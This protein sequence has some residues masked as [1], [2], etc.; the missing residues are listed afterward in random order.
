MSSRDHRLDFVKGFLVF[1]MVL[2]HAMN[3]FSSVSAELYG[4]LRF[5]NGGFVFI[6]GYVI[7]VFYRPNAGAGLQAISTRLI[8]RGGKLLLIFT[9]LNLAIG[10]LGLTSYKNVQFGLGTL[11]ADLQ[12]VYLR[13]DSRSMAF[14]ILAPIAYVLLLAPLLLSMNRVWISVLAIGITAAASIYWWSGLDWPNLFFVL[15]GLSGLI[16]G[17]LLSYDRMHQIESPVFLLTGFVVLAAAMNWL[18][19]HAVAYSMGILLLLKIVYDWAAKFDGNGRFMATLVLVGQYSLVAYIAQIAF[20]YA[21]RQ[22]LPEQGGLRVAALPI[23]LVLT[24]TLMVVLA[25]ALS[26]LR[27]CSS[28]FDRAYRSVF[29]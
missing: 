1:V 13:G 17:R 9:A 6:T 28:V 22:I 15:V 18:S 19:S 20:L 7:S 2:Y 8:V 26:R 12:G 10:L 16:A 4:Y 5:V 25:V 3:Y 23:A 29:A 24:G 14:R 27:A 11:A 21:L